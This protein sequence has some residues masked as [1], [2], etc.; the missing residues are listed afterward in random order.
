M[1][2]LGEHFLALRSAARQLGSHPLGS[3]L[4]ALVIGIALALPAGGLLLLDNA[5]RALGETSGRPEISIFMNEKADRAASDE[6][7]RRLDNDPRVASQ[8]FVPRDEALKQLAESG[9]ADVINDL[10]GNPLPDAFVVMPK[11]EDPVLF[12]DLRETF[13]G[14]PEVAHVQLDSAWIER[15]HAMLEL[16]RQTV[17]LLAFLLASALVIVTFNTIRLQLLTQRAEI[18]VSRLLGATD[19]YI[20]RPFLWQGALQGLLGGF[21]AWALLGA[22]ISALSEP[23]ARLANSYGA[24]FTL[25]RPDALQVAAMLGIVAALGLL[26]AL[27]S[28]NRHLRLAD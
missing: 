22:M 20:R 19:R 28:A 12:N 21:I 18:E 3:L 16:G 5:G 8:R 1:T 13:A 23:V 25:Q 15:L 6:I 10:P 26:G 4:T 24:M 9:L 7:A 2:W 17:M 14:W 11:G 27:L